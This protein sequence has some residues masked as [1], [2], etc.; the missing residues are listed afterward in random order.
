MYL[1][2]K[3]QVQSRV[4]RT[5]HKGDYIRRRHDCPGCRHRFSTVE[6]TAEDIDD[7]FRARELMR[8]LAEAL[9]T[10]ST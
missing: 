9:K 2:P 7:L 6:L 4:L 10:F 5:E 1:C 3:C 8:K